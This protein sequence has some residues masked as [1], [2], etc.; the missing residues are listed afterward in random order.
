MFGFI[1]DVFVRHGL[2]A[3][4]S[5]WDFYPKVI[6][7]GQASAHLWFLIC[8]LYVQMFLKGFVRYLVCLPWVAILC[9]GLG[10]VSLASFFMNIWFFGYPFR[11]FG[12]VLSGYAL[13]CYVEKRRRHND[14]Q[15]AGFWC[16]LSV[17]GIIVHLCTGVIPY[18]AFIKDWFVAM[19]VLLTFVSI[20]E[21]PL[22]YKYISSFLGST[23][24]GV[25][26]VHPIITAGVGLGL[27][28]LF[29]SPFGMNAIFVDW[30]TCYFLALI[31]A[32]IMSKIPLIN[33]FVR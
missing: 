29:T 19:P 24:M 25:Y 17:I 16:A 8:L 13:R 27:K 7:G 33:R 10:C 21:I 20:R 4:W 3:K 30:L 9:I 5:D 14:E 32:L 18:F 1:F 2:N 22:R 6:F 28:R 12:F 26:L 23:S 31:C 15:H 11:M